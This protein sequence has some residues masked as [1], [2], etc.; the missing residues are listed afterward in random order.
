MLINEYQLGSKTR[1][2]RE[3]LFVLSVR[4]FT[5]SS[6]RVRGSYVE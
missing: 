4:Y 3:S 5:I 2:G 6:Y 1:P